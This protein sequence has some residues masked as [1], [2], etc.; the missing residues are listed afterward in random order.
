MSNERDV[1]Y[2]CIF[3]KFSVCLLGSLEDL[4][5]DVGGALSQRFYVTAAGIFFSRLPS[6]S[7]AM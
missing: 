7:T 4:L 1:E 6:C 2:G 3:T 5:H